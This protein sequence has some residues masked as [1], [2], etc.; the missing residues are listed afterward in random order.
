MVIL[1]YFDLLLIKLKI[2]QSVMSLPISL[3]CHRKYGKS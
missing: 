2:S 3:L 1:A